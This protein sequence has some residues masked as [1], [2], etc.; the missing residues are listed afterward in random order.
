MM[1]HRHTAAAVFEEMDGLFRKQRP[2]L[3]PTAQRN[4]QVFKSVGGNRRR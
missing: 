2:Q 3:P 4:M 1:R